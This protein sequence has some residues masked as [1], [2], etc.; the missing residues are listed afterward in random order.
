MPI[1]ENMKSLI[2]VAFK[3]INLNISNMFTRVTNNYTTNYKVEKGATL[4]QVVVSD[5]E[6]AE[7]FANALKSQPT[8]E[9]VTSDTEQPDNG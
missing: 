9:Q 7:A 1:L 6:S 8:Q 3:N 5:R 4:L 2:E